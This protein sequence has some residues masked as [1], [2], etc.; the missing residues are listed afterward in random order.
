MTDN[1]DTLYIQAVA[2][3]VEK[4][5]QVD[6]MIVQIRKGQTRYGRQTFVIYRVNVC[7]LE[8]LTGNNPKNR[9]FVDVAVNVDTKQATPADGQ[10]LPYDDITVYATD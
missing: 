6:E 5:F 7:T 3:F 8:K 9:R 1:R 10:W 4:T 2:E